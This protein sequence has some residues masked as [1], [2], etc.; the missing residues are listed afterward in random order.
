MWLSKMMPQVALFHG[1]IMAITC[2]QCAALNRVGAK[3]CNHC[4]HKL[5]DSH[6]D[7]ASADLSVLDG[8]ETMLLDTTRDTSH[9]KV[10][11]PDSTTL[12]SAG[13]L[14]GEVS[15]TLPSW[16]I[17]N[18]RPGSNRFILWGSIAAA[19]LAVAVGIYWFDLSLSQPGTT[20]ATGM[21]VTTPVP[22]PLPEPV[23]APAPE[24]MPAIAPA[25]MPT[26]EIG[27]IKTPPRIERKP[28]AAKPAL[29]PA[30]PKPS[31]T[32]APIESRVPTHPVTE[33]PMSALPTRPAP[34]AA[35][36]APVGPSS[37]QEACGKRVFLAL[38]LC[39]QEQCQTPQF[40]NHAQC[41]QMRQLQKESQQRN[42]ERY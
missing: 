11:T 37:P 28:V 5:T 21:P 6:P 18:E 35:P 30:P 20:A 2:Q 10:T 22:A 3:F 19:S 23:P 34:L 7:L 31:P 17:Q 25:P 42:M 29:P 24:S 39:M 4:G 9:T 41:V 8:P 40:S 1:E 13:T 33:A 16:L 26:P 36:A 27:N 14:P 38:A 32:P 15:A 12:H